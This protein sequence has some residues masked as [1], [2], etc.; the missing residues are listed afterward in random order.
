MVETDSHMLAK[1]LFLP[2]VQAKIVQSFKNVRPPSSLVYSTENVDS[3]YLLD[4][5]GGLSD[6]GVTRILS[7]LTRPPNWTTIRVNKCHAEVK[8]DQSLQTLQNFV[9]EVRH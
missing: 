6:K 4:F 5:K 2:E 3:S 9:N 7:W 8:T 1:T